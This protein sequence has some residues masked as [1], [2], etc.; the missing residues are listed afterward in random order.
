MKLSSWKIDYEI[1]KK[2][3]W[4]NWPHVYLDAIVKEVLEVEEEF[5]KNN[6]VYLEDELWDIFWD[7]LCLLHWLEKDWM[8][9]DVKNVFYR[10]YEKYD[11]RLSWIKE[12]KNWDDIK[13]I[14]K[15]KLLEEHKKK[16]L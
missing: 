1:E 13:K 15:K 9:D 8:I 5:K 6:S 2:S 10:C 3:W 7:F 12:W 11:L 14:Q 16:Y 4:Y